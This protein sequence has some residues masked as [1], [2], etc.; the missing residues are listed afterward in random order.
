[1]ARRRQ[2]R[3]TEALERQPQPEATKV[4]FGNSVLLIPVIS[5]GALAAYS[6]NLGLAVETAAEPSVSHYWKDRQDSET[7]STKTS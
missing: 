2:L 7:N 5:G 4:E 1:L 3:Q 6:P